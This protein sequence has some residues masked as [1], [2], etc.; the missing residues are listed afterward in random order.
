M[1]LCRS[2]GRS[3]SPNS[4]TGSLH[5]NRERSEEQTDFVES[6]SLKW[7]SKSKESLWPM[8]ITIYCKPWKVYFCSGPKSAS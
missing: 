1:K 5:E 6:T 4:L 7:E 2:D 3:Q 8:F